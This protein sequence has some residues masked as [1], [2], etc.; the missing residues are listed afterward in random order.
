[1][2]L[3]AYPRPIFARSFVLLVAVTPLMTIA[4]PAKAG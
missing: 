3:G 2:Q 4:V 1:M